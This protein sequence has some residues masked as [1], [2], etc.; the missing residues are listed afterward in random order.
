MKCISP[1]S[2]TAEG[3]QLR[4]AD[5]RHNSWKIQQ[6]RQSHRYELFSRVFSMGW[7]DYV[8]R[9]GWV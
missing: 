3:P 2:R 8:T 7:V 6:G 5:S 4:G 9:K 1:R